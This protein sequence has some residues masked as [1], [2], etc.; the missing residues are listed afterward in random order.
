MYTPEGERLAMG[1]FGY[2]VQQPAHGWSEQNPEDYLQAAKAVCQEMA[3]EARRLD[4]RIVSVGMSTQTPTLVFCDGEGKEVAPA[5]IWQD[6][7]AGEESRRLEEIGSD[8]ERREW[9][10]MDLPTGAASTP[11]KLLWMAG[12]R[13]EHWAKAVWV[14][15]PKD[16][17]LLH[18]TGAAVTDHWCSKGMV[19]IR[20]GEAPQGFLSHLRRRGTI[21]PAPRRPDSIAGRVTSGAARMFGLPEGVPVTV[22]WSDALCGILATGALHDAGKGFVISGTSEIVGVSSPPR[23]AAKGLYWAPEHLLPLRGLG[24]HFGPTQ[25][26]GSSLQWL[27]G[28]FGRPAEELLEMV[29]LLTMTGLCEILCRPYLLGERAPYWDH[30]LTASFEGLRAQ[31]GMGDLVYAVLQGVA[32]QERLVLET[33]EDGNAASSVALAGGTTRSAAWNRIRSDVLQR[34]IL[35]LEDEEASLRGAALLAFGAQGTI[36]LAAPPEGWFLASE[37]LPDAGRADAAALLMARFRRLPT[38]T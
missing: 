33:A 29:A 4:I 30:T 20:S 2:P 14:L 18:L 7:R 26:G 34:R 13:P 17:L 6:S 23:P 19:H 25:A 8:A 37:I 31:H 10:G 22:G 12:N 3:G 21:C 32:L 28:L 5:I 38:Y 9:F 24:A 1:A 27:A 16:Y 11:A 36:D 15:Q 35:R